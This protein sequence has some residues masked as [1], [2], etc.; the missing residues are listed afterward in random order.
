MIYDIG[1]R[2]SVVPFGPEHL[3]GPYLG[4]FQDQQVCR[5]NSHGKFPLSRASAER[6]VESANSVT[7]VTWAIEHDRHGH[8][9]NVG[10]TDLSF[11]NRSAKFGILI[12]NS[13]H[14]GTGVGY[15]AA[16]ALITHGFMKLNLERISCGTAASNSPMI[17]LALKLGMVE[18]GRRRSA[19]YLE[20][21]RVDVVEFGLLRA[22]SQMQ[23]PQG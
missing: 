12:G 10:L 15:R 18:E 21:A 9:G 2:Y 20:G 1:N 11:V 5:F 6:F 8:V 7:T 13:E 16:Q 22:D 14:L 23:G 19:L 17:A 4:W 3:D